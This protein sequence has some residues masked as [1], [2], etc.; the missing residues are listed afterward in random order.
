M[1][2]ILNHELGRTLA[3]ACLLGGLQAPTTARQPI[4]GPSAPERIPPL[5][6]AAAWAES[7]TSIT[8]GAQQQ[9]NAT[10]TANDDPKGL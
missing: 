10:A 3:I 4:R 1:R 8:S 5:Q 9:L 7:T 2:N 6:R